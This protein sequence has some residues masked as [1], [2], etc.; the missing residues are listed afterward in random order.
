MIFW[1]GV[2]FL[3]LGVAAIVGGAESWLAMLLLSV[4]LGAAT[5]GIIDGVAGVL[6]DDRDD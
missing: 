1:I 2:Y 5:I 3:F 6:I 4:G